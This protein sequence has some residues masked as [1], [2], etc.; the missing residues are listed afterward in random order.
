MASTSTLLNIIINTSYRQT[1][2]YMSIR[3]NTS[4]EAKNKLIFFFSSTSIPSCY[5]VVVRFAL[6]SG[7]VDST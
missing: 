6:S 5:R 7:G 2:V 1:I 3:Y 4:K